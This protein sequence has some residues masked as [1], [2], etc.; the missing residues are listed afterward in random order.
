MRTFKISIH[1]HGFN[2]VEVMPDGGESLVASSSS[3]STYLKLMSDMI[4]AGTGNS[5]EFEVKR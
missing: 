1:E 4:K 3:V 2:A 5:L